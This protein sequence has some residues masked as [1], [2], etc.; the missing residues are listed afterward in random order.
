MS[1]LIACDLDRTLIYSA[2]FLDTTPAPPAASTMTCVEVYNGSPL[3][4][5]TARAGALLL[6]VADQAVFVPST[7]RTVAQYSRIDLPGKPFRYAVTSNGGNI[8]V[9]SIADSHW[10]S[11]VADVIGSSA[12]ALAEVAAALQA[13]VSSDWVRS[14]RQAEEL[15]CYLVVD[16]TRIPDGFMAQWQD[17][18]QPRGWNVSRQGRKIYTVPNTLCKS[19]AIAEVRRRLEDDGVA[20][21]RLVL[22]AGDGALDAEMLRYA[23]AAIRPRH[24]ELHKLGWKSEHTEVTTNAGVIAGEE[25]LTWFLDRL[26]T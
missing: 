11:S 26:G 17:W 1:A 13:R 19:R 9:N 7:T 8:L 2:N 20:G 12:T 4:F 10:H 18:C 6:A 3:S 22:A 24:G 21:P 14:F 15:F 23:D 5:M 25:I 16:E